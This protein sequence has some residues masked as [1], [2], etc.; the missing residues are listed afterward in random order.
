[1]TGGSVGAGSIS[2][3]GASTASPRARLY[4]GTSQGQVFRLDDADRAAA[5]SIPADCWSGMG[6][7][8]GAYVSCLGVDPGN[9]DRAILVFSNYGVRSVFA[10]TDAGRT[11]SD[12]SGNLEERPDGS[13]SGPSIRWAA[14]QRYGGGRI[15]FLG[16]STGLYSST[17]LNGASTIWVQEGAASIGRVVVDMIATR[18]A[19]GLVAVGTHGQGVF[20]G[21]SP[22]V[23]P[24]PAES[25]GETALGRPYPNPVGGDGNP[26]VTFAYTLREAARVRLSI[27]DLTGE[28]VAVLVDEYREAGLQPDAYW[29]PGGVASGVYFCS[30]VAGSTTDAVKFVVLR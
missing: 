10:T 3:L 28:E 8:P 18:S 17:E 24:P 5:S 26:F 9:G 16:T 4:Y 13:G 29:D 23:G 7:P 20:S 6:L 14:V 25:G 30:L 19:D 2:A 22:A 12:V 11:W 21:I 1:M 27:Y 15:Y